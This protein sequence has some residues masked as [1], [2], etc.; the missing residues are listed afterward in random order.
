[1][2]IAVVD[3]SVDDLE[4][5]TVF[6]EHAFG[7]GSVTPYL[8]SDD[9]LSQFTPHRFDLVLINLTMPQ[10]DGFELLKRI[11]AVDTFPLAVALTNDSAD[12]AAIRA[13]DAGFIYVISK[14]VWDFEQVCNDL[15]RLG[16]AS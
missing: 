5:L 12:G 9:F 7:V 3:N 15:R 16:P 2:R 13:H 8:R 14:P 11:R 4:L 1:M 6:L 10:I